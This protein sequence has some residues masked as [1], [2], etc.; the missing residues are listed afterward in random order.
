MTSEINR[1][2]RYR[3][4]EIYGHHCPGCGS[5]KTTIHHI[6]FKCDKKRGLIEPGFQVEKKANYCPLC[7]KCQKELHAKVDKMENGVIYERKRQQPRK[8]NKRLS[9]RKGR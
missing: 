1:G 4:N 3:I 2:D 7:G 9:K 6:V 5:E 8:R